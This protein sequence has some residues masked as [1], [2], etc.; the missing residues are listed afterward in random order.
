MRAFPFLHPHQPFFFFSSTDLK[1]S[2]TTAYLGATWASHGELKVGL[3][4]GGLIIDVD[5]G[6]LIIDVSKIGGRVEIDVGGDGVKSRLGE[7]GVLKLGLVGLGWVK[8]GSEF[9]K[10]G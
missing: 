7:G 9:G 10:L 5:R 6:G 4:G 1:I 2:T 8:V 3:C